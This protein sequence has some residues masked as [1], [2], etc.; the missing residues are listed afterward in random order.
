MKEEEE[1]A[2]EHDFPNYTDEGPEDE[3][4][5]TSTKWTSR[6]SAIHQGVIEKR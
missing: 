3:I 1:A 6:E 2:L 4:K 5:D